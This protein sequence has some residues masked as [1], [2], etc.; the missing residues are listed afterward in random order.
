VLLSADLQQYKYW[1]TSKDLELI[2]GFKLRSNDIKHNRQVT[3]NNT[4]KNLNQMQHINHA[5]LGIRKPTVF[6][7]FSSK[8]FSGSLCQGLI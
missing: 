4:F 8:V 6:F 3:L 5:C 7:I 2:Q 1:M